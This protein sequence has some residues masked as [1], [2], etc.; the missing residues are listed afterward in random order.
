MPHFYKIKTFIFLKEYVMRNL[1]M[2]TV[3]KLNKLKWVAYVARMENEKCV[4]NIN[5]KT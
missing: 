2:C 5:R 3:I 1:I 4:Q